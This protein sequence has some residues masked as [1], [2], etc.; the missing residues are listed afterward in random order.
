MRLPLIL[1]A[2]LTISLAVTVVELLPSLNSNVNAIIVNNTDFSVNVLDNWA[3]Q[4][5]NNP[6]G[7]KLGTNNLIAKIFGGGP[8]VDLIPN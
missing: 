2:I 5:S 4:D 1:T 6:L 8:R 7:S 3:Y